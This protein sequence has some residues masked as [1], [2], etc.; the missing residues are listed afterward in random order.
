MV[1]TLLEYSPEKDHTFAFFAS[2]SGENPVHVSYS[3]DVLGASGFSV[4]KRL[5]EVTGLCGVLSA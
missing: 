5:K 2:V 4:H 1:H 3:L